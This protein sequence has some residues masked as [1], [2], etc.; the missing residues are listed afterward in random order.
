M[1]EVL[2]SDSS[3]FAVFPS[4]FLVSGFDFSALTILFWALWRHILVKTKAYQRKKMKKKIFDPTKSVH[5]VK[6]NKIQT[7]F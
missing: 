1:W 3:L 4:Q 2:C 6:R 5:F 7:L